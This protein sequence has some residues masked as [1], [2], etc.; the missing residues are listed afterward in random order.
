MNRDE[1]LSILGRHRGDMEAYGVVSLSMF[2][3][4]ARDEAGPQSDVDLLVR[5]SGPATFDQYMGL[6]F[7]LEDLL[8]RPVDLVTERALRPRLRERVETELVRVG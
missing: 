5:F 1:V 7:F 6:K 8:N 2:G 4:M 3:S